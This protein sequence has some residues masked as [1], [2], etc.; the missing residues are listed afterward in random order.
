MPIAKILI[1][2]GEPAGIGA[3]IIVKLAQQPCSAQLIVCGDPDLLLQTAKALELP[4]KLSDYPS[5]ETSLQEAS[6][7]HKKG[8]LWVIPVPLAQPVTAGEL[9]PTNADYVIQTLTIAAEYASSG[10]VD[11]ILTAPVHKGIINQAALPFSGHTEFFAQKAGVDKVV[12]MLATEGLKVALV[13][14]HLPLKHVSAAI[15][16]QSLSQTLKILTADLQSKFNLAKPKILVCGLN[17]HAGE[18]GHLGSEEIETIIP[19][20]NK[21]RPLLDAQLS[22]PVPAD[23]AFT[24]KM[25]EQ[26]D[27]VLAMYHDQGLPVLKHK[28]FGQ[29][30]NLT[31]G[32][33]YIRTSVDHGTGL[34]IAGKNIANIDSLQYALQFTLDL[35][36]NSKSGS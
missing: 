25:I 10:Q 5:Q 3:E 23:T 14:T 34:D 35:I 24:P 21:L 9:N 29:A 4:L 1:T 13:T 17:P 2:A 6:L 15:S 26:Y 27:A 19:T 11:A 8:H 30:I 32:L 7:Q 33:P 28:G 20:L 22:E 18:S 12:M 16:E 31:L 36:A